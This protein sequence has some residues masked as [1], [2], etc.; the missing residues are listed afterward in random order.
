M[1]I[2]NWSSDV[3]SSDLIVIDETRSEALKILSGGAR[4]PYPFGFDHH[5]A[6]AGSAIQKDEG[7]RKARVGA[8]SDMIPGEAGVYVS[9]HIGRLIESTGRLRAHRAQLHASRSTQRIGP[10]KPQCQGLGVVNDAHARSGQI[11]RS[12]SGRT[13]GRE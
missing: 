10:S 7:V 13:A 4:L 3:C 5:A 6:D 1:R 8:T 11:A 9:T 2:S 12:E